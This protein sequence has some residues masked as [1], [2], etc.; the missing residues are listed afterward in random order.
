MGVYHFMGLGQGIGA[1][2]CAVDYI[3]SSLELIALDKANE[4][5][6]RLFA[7][8]GGINHNEHLSGKIEAIVLFT[9]RQVIEDTLGAFEYEGCE[10][11][12]GVRTEINNNLRKLWKNHNTHEGRKVFWC[13][14]DI[15][16][17][18]DCFEK[19]LKV[20]Y[21]FSPEGKQG[22]EIWINLT[23]GTN[24]VGQALLSMARLTG[25]SNKHYLISQKQD[26]QK[27][28][29]IPH[30]HKIEPNRD[31]YFNIV[32]FF[33]TTLDTVGFYSILESLQEACKSSTQ[34]VSTQDLLNRLKQRG[35]FVE[36]DVSSFTKQYMVKMQG[37]GYTHFTQETGLT[38]LSEEGRRFLEDELPELENMINL[39][40]LLKFRDEENV[41]EVSKTWDWFNMDVL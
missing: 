34:G 29:T 21:R 11:P 7:G 35:L 20:A 26:V 24:V 8:S 31:G 10:K 14:V 4:A 17:F 5:T 12:G 38:T 36:L 41:V 9:S 30:G 33:R 15:N 23:G 25:L 22:K 3:E 6:K 32:P 19:M 18:W 13:E 37:L 1:V 28:I 27:N 40:D 2:T 39:E 16:D